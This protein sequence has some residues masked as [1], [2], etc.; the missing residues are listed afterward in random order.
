VRRWRAAG[1]HAFEETVGEGWHEL[2]HPDDADGYLEAVRVGVVERRAW[3]CRM[4]FRRRDPAPPRPFRGTGT[5]YPTSGR[6]TPEETTMTA[7]DGPRTIADQSVAQMGGR[8]SILTRQRADHEELHRLI[9][10]AR[11]TREQGGVEHARTLRALARLVFTH[12]FAEEAVLFPAAR[13]VLPEGDPLTLHIETAHQEVDDLVA[14]LD[15]SS[16][17]DPEHAELMERTFAAL[18]EDVRSEEDVLLPR[19]QELMSPRQLRVL[20]LQWELVRRVSPTRAHPRVSRRPPGQPL[21]ALPLTVLDRGRDQLQ[22]VDERTGGRWRGAVAAADR[23][24][25]FAAGAVERLPIVQ[26][27]ERPE[28]DVDR[29]A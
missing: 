8:T 10:R 28:T 23:R 5:G 21:S 27:G 12:A 17:H 20:G 3:R 7:A 22:R 2:L 6:S 18:E 19:L 29:R 14:R 15:R 26:R 16:E 4:R 13:K 9:G 24:L 1:R 25:A 11:A